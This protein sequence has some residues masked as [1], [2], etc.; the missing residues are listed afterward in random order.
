MNTNPKRDEMRETAYEW[1]IENTRQFFDCFNETRSDDDAVVEYH[2]MVDGIVWSDE[3]PDGSSV[4]LPVLQKV[5]CILVHTRTSQ[6]L[7][8][9]V[10]QVGLEL[11]SMIREKCPNWCFNH[12]DRNSRSRRIDYERVK[13]RFFG[14]LGQIGSSPGADSRADH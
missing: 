6:I 14:K 10:P 5:F 4:D 2:G 12:P 8:E 3:L 7:G 13:A 9:T 11:M 1:C